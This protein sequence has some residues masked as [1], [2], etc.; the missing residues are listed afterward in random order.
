LLY[1]FSSLHTA[2]QFEV[3]SRYTVPRTTGRALSDRAFSVHWA[4]DLEQPTTVRS[5]CR[6]CH[7]V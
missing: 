6:Q 3:R 5:W 4:C 7:P 1:T 2:R